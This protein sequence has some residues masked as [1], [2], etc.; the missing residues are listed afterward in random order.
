MKW[1][2]KRLRNT[3]LAASWIECPG[4]LRC[5]RECP[6]IRLDIAGLASSCFKLSN[7]IL[8]LN[9]CIKSGWN[10]PPIGALPLTLL[11]SDNSVNTYK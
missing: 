1:T 10:D 3:I 8:G 6:D 5:G 11:P 7:E 2:I 4:E 9:S